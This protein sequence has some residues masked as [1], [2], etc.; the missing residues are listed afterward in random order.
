MTR[1][2]LLR[3]IEQRLEAGGKAAHEGRW[4]LAHGLGLQSQELLADLGAEVGP[5]VEATI[6]AQLK[7][8]LAG[9]PLQLL[10]GETEFFGLKFRVAEGVLIPRP[11]TEGLVELGLKLI[12]FPNPRVLD[13]GTGS[14]VIAVAIKHQR[15]DAQV[16]ATDVDATA[17]AL[18]QE[19][20]KRLNYAVQLLARRYTADLHDLDLI[21]ANP[22][23]LPESYRS[24]AP[25]ELAFERPEALYSG[26]DGL[27]MPRQLLVHA[28]Q[29]LRAGGW[30]ALELSP[31]NVRVLAQEAGRAGWAEV[32]VEADLAGRDRYFIARKSS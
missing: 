14:G 1:L 4:L 9:Y 31:E 25:P 17:L 12:P 8:R 3:R 22:P 20:A 27:E 30:L 6:E 23:Y 28:W 15:P 16:W 7:R 29:A 24:E 11:E 21:I 26:R 18:A 10:L 5:G 2:Q 19:N 13:V 32:K